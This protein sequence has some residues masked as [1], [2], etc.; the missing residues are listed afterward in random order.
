MKK[1]IFGLFALLLVLTLT[2]TES[3]RPDFTEFIPIRVDT[4]GN[5]T[6]YPTI[7]WIDES[8]PA[9]ILTVDSLTQALAEKPLLDSFTA[10]TGAFLTF[11]NGCKLWINPGICRGN[12]G[13]ALT[14]KLY[15]ELIIVQKIGGMMRNN[16]PTVT[17]N[18]QLLTS[19]GEVYLRIYQP[20]GNDV[21]LAQP[22]SIRYGMTTAVPNPAFTGF[23]AETTVSRFQNTWRQVTDSVVGVAT[24]RDSFRQQGTITFVDTCFMSLGRLGWTNCDRFANEPNL[25]RDICVS[26][27][28]SFTNS[29]TV[30][31]MGFP[32]L[33]A[34]IRM[35]GDTATRTFRIAPFYSGVPTGRNVIYVS[36]SKIGDNYYLAY[37][38]TT[39]TPSSTCIA[40][41]PRRVTLADIVTYLGSL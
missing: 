25:T 26:L 12:S 1:L 18:G 16:R 6:I 22:V 36:V 27:P 4:L 34:A 15:V 11:P 37:N 8:N 10:Q 40:L 23:I 13:A 41:V 19:G 9:A 32:Q 3:C 28:D 30:V 35:V 31:F 2:L 29:N 5:P 21:T 39:V 14:G 33:V 7:R 38:T 20:N 24:N 17:T